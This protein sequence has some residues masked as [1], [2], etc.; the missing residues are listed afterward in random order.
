MNWAGDDPDENDGVSDAEQPIVVAETDPDQGVIVV[1]F[2]KAIEVALAT[3]DN[4]GERLFMRE[5]LLAIRRLT[6]HDVARALRDQALANT[7][8]TFA[9]LGLKKKIFF[10]NAG[11]VPQLDG[12]C[13]PHPRPVQEV[14]KNLLL[15][16]IGEHFR[17]DRHF[18]VGPIDPAG[19]PAVINEIVSFCFQIGR[20]HV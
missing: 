17:H 19:V 9:P 14:D 7:L 8:D 15:D 20:A 6:D 18:A 13:L 16:P 4:A 11:N 2:E 1:R 10:L 12:R 5:I 3:V